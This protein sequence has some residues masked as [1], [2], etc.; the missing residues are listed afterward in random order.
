MLLYMRKVVAT[1]ARTL[2]FR[3]ND[4]RTW[5]D[6]IRLVTPVCNDIQSRRG[7]YNFRVICDE[8]TNTSV[9]I[10]RNEMHGRILIQ[11]TKTAEII[12]VE[13]TLLPTGASFEEV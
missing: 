4:E 8:T 3:P 6:F 13:F 11:P 10:N 9:R 2:L 7:I 5:R 1:A 12:T